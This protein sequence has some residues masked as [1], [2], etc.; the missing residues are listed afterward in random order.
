MTEQWRFIC[1]SEEHT[2]I[3]FQKGRVWSPAGEC[4]MLI[5]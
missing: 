3:T 2:A 1:L 4:C 5:I